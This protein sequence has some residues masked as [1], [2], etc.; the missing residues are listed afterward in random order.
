MSEINLGDDVR[1]I[2]TGFEGMAIARQDGLFETPSIKV[3][4]RNLNDDKRP[5]DSIW[6]EESRLE[7]VRKSIVFNDDGCRITES[8]LNEARKTQ[9]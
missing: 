3:Q 1:D 6:F 7:R 2:V 8:E 9:S 4:Q 5:M